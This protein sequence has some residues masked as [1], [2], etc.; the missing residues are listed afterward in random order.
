MSLVSPEHSLAAASSREKEKHYISGDYFIM[1][2]SIQVLANISFVCNSLDTNT[3]KTKHLTRALKE[4]YNDQFKDDI[5]PF[6]TIDATNIIWGTDEPEHI[7]L[8]A[9]KW[10]ETLTKDLINRIEN[11]LTGPKEDNNLPRLGSPET[12]MLAVA[13]TATDDI[14]MSITE[15][16][17]FCIPQDVIHKN[18][19]YSCILGDDRLQDIQQHP[20][21]YAVVQL[22]VD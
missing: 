17:L 6:D 12:Q 11:F 13:A 19:F 2:L 5:Y 8:T 3:K 22:C 1:C 21:N 9:R 15:H 7:I 14:P 18:R 10:N 16:L 20:E 4:K